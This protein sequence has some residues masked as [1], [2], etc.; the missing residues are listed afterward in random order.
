L[1]KHLTVTLKRCIVCPCNHCLFKGIFI[2]YTL[3]CTGI[4]LLF[5]GDQQVVGK[6]SCLANV[7]LVGSVFLLQ[8]ILPYSGHL[9]E[10]MSCYIT[11]FS[12]YLFIELIIV[13]GHGCSHAIYDFFCLICLISVGCIAL[14]LGGNVACLGLSV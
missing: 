4:F 9:T 3:G 12:T 5:P 10:L 14:F 7:Y 1:H 13:T 6:H 8:F 2:R 11:N